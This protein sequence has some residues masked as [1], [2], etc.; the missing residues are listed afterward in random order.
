[1]EVNMKQTVET[2]NPAELKPHP[3]NAKIY[4]DGLNPAIVQSINPTTTFNT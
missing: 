4:G 1:M 3:L 2:R